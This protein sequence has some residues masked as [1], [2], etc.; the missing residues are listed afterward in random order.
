MGRGRADHTS[1]RRSTVHP[2]PPR[3][4][5]APTG[6]APLPSQEG[7]DL[8]I[9]DLESHS[10]SLPS[11]GAQPQPS[12]APQ[13]S[14]KPTITPQSIPESTPLPAVD[15]LAMLTSTPTPV[16]RAT[17]T[18][19]PVRTKY[20]PMK[21]QTRIAGVISNRGISS[22]N[23]F[24]TPLGRYEKVMKDAIGSRWYAYMEQRR[25]MAN[26]GTLKVHFV[27][28]RRG[29]VQNLKIMENTSN[30]TF[31]NICLQ[32]ILEASL[33]PIPAR[34]SCRPCV[35]HIAGS[36]ARM[37]CHRAEPVRDLRV[38]RSR[39][40]PTRARGETTDAST[41]LHRRS[42]ADI[43]HQR[44]RRA[45]R[46]PG[47]PGPAARRVRRGLYGDHCVWCEPVGLYAARRGC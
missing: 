16:A 7:R 20:Q 41:H 11:E 42:A 39:E 46:R 44:T 43:R 1:C 25:E 31:A 34:L 14:A 21:Q 26:I 2:P 27:I 29:K 47:R 8:P 4:L 6:A 38:P 30:E 19:A 24:G 3:R 23:A 45:A 18:P 12:V 36:S 5:G 17:P 15:Q 13:P 10:Y 32:A 28:D 37:P 40:S 22:V 35:A 9:T 33:P